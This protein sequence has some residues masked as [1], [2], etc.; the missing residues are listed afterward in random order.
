MRRRPRDK[1]NKAIE[2]VTTFG[3]N[4]GTLGLVLSGGGARAAYQAGALKALVPFLKASENPLQ[5][6]IGSSI[7][8]INGLVIAACMKDGIEA[9][10]DELHSL[11]RERNFKNTF[12]GT[13]SGAFMRAIK[14]AFFQYLSPGPNPTSDSIFDPTPLMQRIDG[15]IA[16]YGGLK[17]ENRCPSL[18]AVSVITTVEG[19]E[20]KPLVFVSSHKQVDEAI[21]AG[22]S[23]QFCY[24]DDI[25]AKHGFASAALPSVLPPVELDTEHGMVRLVDGGI[26]SNV[27]VDPAMRLGAERIIAIDVSG[28]D[29]WLDRYNEP[30]DKAPDWEVRPTEGSF[31]MRPPYIFMKRIDKPL[32]PILKEAVSS[33]TRKFISAVGPTWPCFTL[34]KNKLGEDVA[35]ETMSYVALDPDYLNAIME[36]GYTETLNRLR[37]KK[38]PGFVKQG[39]KETDTITELAG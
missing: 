5:I 29:W 35:Y 31:C 14:M 23:F 25:T 10:V 16:Q 1:N 7:G 6:I 3:S 9:A 4:E 18:H 37:N 32:G 11:W 15:V 19:T 26:S 13:P 17:P 39:Q 38:E 2:G 24:V 21:M 22:A 28:R 8:A 12:D 33:S 30:H 34:L 20:R 27:P 36:L